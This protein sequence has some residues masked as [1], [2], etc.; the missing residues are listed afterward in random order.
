MGWGDVWLGFFSGLASG[1]PLA[2]LL[3]TFSFTLGAFVGVGLM[4]AGRKGMKSALPF[5][6]FLAAG[7][8]V[9]LYVPRFFP[10]FLSFF[11]P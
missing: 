3:L 9:A 2:L 8:L 11:F 7:T 4:L 6:P 1:L 10:G 5:A